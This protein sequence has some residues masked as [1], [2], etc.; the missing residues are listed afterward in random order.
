MREREREIHKYR[1]TA[2]CLKLDNLASTIEGKIQIE[3]M[4]WV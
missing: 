2:V 3:V 4:S 1:S